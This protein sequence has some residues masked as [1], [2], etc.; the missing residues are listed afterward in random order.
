MTKTTIIVEKSTRKNLRHIGRKDQTY[1]QLINELISTAGTTNGKKPRKQVSPIG[2][3][4][5]Q[6]LSESR[7]P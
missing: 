1:D 3:L 7:S 2:A 5:G 4:E 6:T